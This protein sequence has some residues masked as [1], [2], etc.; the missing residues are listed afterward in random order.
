MVKTLTSAI[1]LF[2]GLLIASNQIHDHE[3]PRMSLKEYARTIKAAVDPK[4]IACMAKNIFYEAGNETVQGQAAVARVVVNRVMHGFASSPCGVIYQKAVINK[5]DPESGTAEKI[6]LCQFSW[7]CAIKSD[8]SINHP[9]YKQAI[10]I[11]HEVLENDAYRDVVPKT[12]LF[13]HNNQLEP[14]WPYKP[15]AKIGNHIF[16]SKQRKSNDHSSQSR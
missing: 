3:I 15:V 9:K 4:Q 8:I 10:K 1:F 16:Y 13:F 5:L 14:N 2:S 7:V 6:H 11:A 12:A